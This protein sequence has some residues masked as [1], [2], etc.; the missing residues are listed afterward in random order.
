MSKI[1]EPQ[2]INPIL[3]GFIEELITTKGNLAAT[4]PAEIATK[5]IDVFEG[6]MRIKGIDLFEVPVYVAAVS[7]YLNQGDMQGHR[8][9]GAMACYMDIEVAD[10]IFKAAGLQVPYDEDD[11]SMMGL[12]G[13]LSKLIADAL[14][15]RLAAA[16]YTSLMVSNPSVYKNS[17]AGGVDFSKDQ[18]E[19]QE[20]S[21]YFLKHKAL[22]ID[23]TMAPIPK[24]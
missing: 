12:C 16:G 10:K 2:V 4:K 19:K 8:A 21:F 3:T 1:F 9:R 20:I 18:N 22:V 15:D 6:R 23:W 7:F 24:K 13:S 5:P 11:E 14:K 17:I